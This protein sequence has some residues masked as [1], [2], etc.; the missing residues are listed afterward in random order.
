[1]IHRKVLLAAAA[2]VALA[3]V[4]ALA[5]IVAPVRHPPIAS[6]GG[7]FATRFAPSAAVIAGIGSTHDL[8]PV[9]LGAPD[10]DEPKRL[11]EA[12][13]AEHPCTAGP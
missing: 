5:T 4:A 6:S 9:H 2:P 11:A 8:T 13:N 12:I 7:A 1:M 10:P 3:A